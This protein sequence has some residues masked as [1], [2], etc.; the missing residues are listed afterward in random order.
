MNE[1]EIDVAGS[2]YKVGEEMIEPRIGLYT[3]TRPA[4]WAHYG[5]GPYG[6]LVA[7]EVQEILDC[8]GDLHAANSDGL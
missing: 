4:E 8:V 2:D 7:I 6:L 1:N 3:F 5:Y